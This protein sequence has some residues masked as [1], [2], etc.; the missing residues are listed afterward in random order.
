[1]KQDA[2]AEFQHWMELFP[3]PLAVE[4]SLRFL[5]QAQNEVNR[6]LTAF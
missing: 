1:V 6:V 3:R 5:S 4:T 2:T